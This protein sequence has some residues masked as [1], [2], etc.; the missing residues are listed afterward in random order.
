M[1]NLD[2]YSKNYVDDFIGI[3]HRETEWEA[4]DALGNLLRYLGVKEAQDKAVSP[5][6][7]TEFLGTGFDLERLVLF[8]M[9]G[10]LQEIQQEV[11]KWIHKESMNRT[12]L[13]SLIGKLL[14]IGNCIRPG[15]VY[16]N[17]LLNKLPLIM[18]GSM[19][20]IDDTMR[21]GIKW[22]RRFLPEFNA[23]AI[24]WLEQRLKPDTVIATDACLTGIGGQ[25][26]KEYFHQEIPNLILEI[27]GVH[28]TH[29]EMITVMVALKLLAP[30]L[31][32]I[33]LRIYCNNQ[34]VVSILNHG[35]SKDLKLQEL[36]R[37]VTYIQAC[38]N[39]EM[40]AEYI[41][42]DQNCIPDI[43]SRYHLH[44]K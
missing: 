15:M 26:G 39:F 21:L 42:S 12:Q 22:W 20:K 3:E 35:K 7:I 11:E 29:L 9:E 1:T 5:A 13:E 41:A 18:R 32:G 34:S 16:I 19:Y 43:L 27:P 25:A 44:K 40:Q 36:L 24:M 2:Y 38:Y 10:K 17:H 28:I 23:T 4:Y 14:A 37:E 33:R 6:M 8:V 30:K 31:H